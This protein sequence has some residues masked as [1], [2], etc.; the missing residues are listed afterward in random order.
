[1]LLELRALII[2]YI[3]NNNIAIFDYI[4]NTIK[5]KIIEDD[6]SGIN[7]YFIKN[8]IP[9]NLIVK[10]FKKKSKAKFVILHKIDY[11]L[12]ITSDMI[13]NLI[14]FYFEYFSITNYD[15]SYCNQIENLNSIS[16]D[17]NFNYLII[18]VAS[19][20]Y[21]ANREFI[22]VSKGSLMIK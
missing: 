10:R 19:N 22:F 15:D 16:I 4:I 13:K 18:I 11:N 8:I 6:I 17:S 12:P 9:A 21:K 14:L 5:N 2:S 7:D 3:N 20:S 1:M